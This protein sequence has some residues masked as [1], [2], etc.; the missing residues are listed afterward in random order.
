MAWFSD[1]M[2]RPMTTAIPQLMA[3]LPSA[4]IV[5]CC[6]GTRP[7]NHKIFRLV[8]L[9]TSPHTDRDQ[10]FCDNAVAPVTAADRWCGPNQPSWRYTIDNANGGAHIGYSRS[11]SDKAIESIAADVMQ[12]RQ[13]CN[14]GRV[15]KRTLDNS[16]LPLW[17]ELLLLSSIRLIAV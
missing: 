13:L 4:L 17:L 15:C 16:A 1:S 2:V 12:G 3:L 7:Q 11:Y 8:A 14:H 6:S 5:M 10:P 9:A